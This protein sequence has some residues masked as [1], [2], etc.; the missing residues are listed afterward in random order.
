MKD[1]TPEELTMI[2]KSLEDDIENKADFYSSVA[3]PI[4]GAMKVQ[5]EVR[6]EMKELSA[7][8]VKIHNEIPGYGHISDPDYFMNAHLED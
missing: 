4:A 5:E 7:L 8:A 2:L 1:L 6:E 3:Y